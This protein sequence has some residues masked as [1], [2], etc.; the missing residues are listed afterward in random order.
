[1]SLGQLY[2]EGTVPSAGLD[3]APASTTTPSFDFTPAEIPGE[4]C[5]GGLTFADGPVAPSGHPALPERIATASTSCPGNTAFYGAD[6]GGHGDRRRPGSIDS[7]C[8]RPASWS[9]TPPSIADPEIDYSDFDTD[10]D[11]VV[12][13]FMAVFAGCGGNGA[14]QLTVAGCDYA[15]APYDNVWPHSSSLEFYYSDPETGLPGYTTDDQL[16]NLEGQPLWY[17]DDT[18]SDDDDHRHRRR[19]QGVRPGRALQ[20]QPRD[21][22]RQGQRDLAR[23]RP[24]AR[25]CPTSTPPAAGRPTATGT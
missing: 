19:P 14:S 20:R 24:L 2:P 10:K 22:D 5:T 23:V 25:A 15:D 11:G 21:R 18:Y 3:D 4:T 7:G 1:M 12:D 6:S 8:G 9:T 13:F 17:T 16:K